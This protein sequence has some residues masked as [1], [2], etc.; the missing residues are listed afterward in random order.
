MTHH[1]L[2][3][4][5]VQTLAESIDVHDTDRVTRYGVEVQTK[6][7]GFYDRVLAHV[8]AKDSRTVEL[9]LEDLVRKI[10]SLNIT[11]I[12]KDSFLGKL[13]LFRSVV[14]SPY[15]FAVEYEKVN[16]QVESLSERL[17]EASRRLGK[18]VEVFDKLYEQNLQYLEDL[19]LHVA[20]AESKLAELNAGPVAE[21]KGTAE[22]TGDPMDAHN[23]QDFTQHVERLERRVRDLRVAR[24]IAIQT[25]GQIRM[26]QSDMHVLIEKIQSSTLTSIPLWRNQIAITI[27]QARHRKTLKLQKSIQSATVDMLKRN[28]SLLKTGKIEAARGAGTEAELQAM[29]KVADDLVKAVDDHRP[30]AKAPSSRNRSAAL[31]A[32]GAVVTKGPGV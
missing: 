4:T 9:L 23:L 29:R 27:G 28:S 24:T 1:H 16:A 12:G 22:S 25:A 30:A 32:T 21:L 26:I 13:P 15:R 6:V 14:P 31:G 18:D 11:G 3:P 20:A 2:D 5:R 8:R 7:S 17:G 19:D 10:R